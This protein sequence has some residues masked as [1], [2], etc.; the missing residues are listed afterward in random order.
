M[1]KH[2]L[3]F[4]AANTAYAPRKNTDKLFPLPQGSASWEGVID[5]VNRRI[6][7]QD[8]F[9]PELWKCFVDQFRNLVD[10][11]NNLW[12]CEFWG[13]M[14]RGACM[15]YQY[16]CDKEL[17]A[18]LE[19]SV[20]DL[21][22][23]ADERGRISTYSVET[24][25]D[26][27]DV[28]GRKYVLLGLQHFMEISENEAL[29]EEIVEAMKKHADVFIEDLHATGKP[30]Y[31]CSRHWLGINSVSILEP[32]VRL[33]N[34]TGETRYLDFAT[35][36]VQ[37]GGAEGFDL[38]NAPLTNP[39][40]PSTYP[41]QKAYEMMSC[42]EGLLEYGRTTGEEKWIQSALNLGKQVLETELT[43]IGCAGCT[44]ELFDGS[45][46][47]QFNEEL[48]GTIM[49]ETC[50]SV[51]LMK[52]M[53][54]LMSINAD[55]AFADVIESAFYNDVLGSVN[56]R[57][58]AYEA[59]PTKHNAKEVFHMR[60]TDKHEAEVFPFDSYS[61]LM[62]GTRGIKQAGYRPI[63]ETA[64]YSC[65]AAI[66][67]A[68]TALMARNAVMYTEDGL[69]VLFYEK[70]TVKFLTPKGQ[71]ATL[72]VDTAYPVGDTVTFTF[73]LPA[74]ETFRLALRIPEVGWKEEVREWA[75]GD[76]I[77]LTLD[78]EVKALYSADL[79]AD[80]KDPHFSL[81][82]GPL[83]LAADTE[84]AP[85]DFDTRKDPATENG[86]VLATE[87]NTEIDH[88]L[89]LDIALKD[90]SSMRV[91]DYAS[92]GKSWDEKYPFACWFR[93]G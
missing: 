68:G 86:S 73:S 19:D 76:G 49:Q 1:N 50:V 32:I 20:K 66:A 56:T 35:E 67:A 3:D 82:K 23:A 61:P 28:W 40:G 64:N 72:T 78:M 58:V 77:T 42:F 70:G 75:D 51:T 31:L 8:I 84:V 6:A 26:G 12:R 4:C 83:V 88:L 65:C 59:D 21:L 39:D 55:P 74:P 13:K 79:V 30:L 5:A 91:I 25:L 44:H 54:Q 41:V 38:F 17:Y 81:R 92:A 57:D 29:N 89:A 43:V 15:T 87:A 60:Y 69:A 24:Q 63:T 47:A 53:M 2:I 48:A 27:W 9:K 36:L 18:I 93:R 85:F 71:E 37:S 33:Y 22:S 16:T 90:G 62:K 34:I 46:I 7:K 52:F 14:M 11:G 80:D 10:G 45:R